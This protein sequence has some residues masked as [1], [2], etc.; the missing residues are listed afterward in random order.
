MGSQANL[1]KTSGST[2]AQVR[3]LLEPQQSVSRELKMEVL[4]LSW[5]RC[6][7]STGE[8]CIG[9]RDSKEASWSVA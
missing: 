3:G 2:M 4:R 7:R 1:Q 9:N 6:L 8:T 5:K